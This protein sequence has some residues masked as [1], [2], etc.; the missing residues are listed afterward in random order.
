MSLFLIKLYKPK[1]QT[2]NQKRRKLDCWKSSAANDNRTNVIGLF[3]P[4][5]PKVI[6]INVNIVKEEV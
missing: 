5:M 6:D 1:V 3:I 4:N 2:Q